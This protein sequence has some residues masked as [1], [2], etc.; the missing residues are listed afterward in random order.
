M[1]LHPLDLDA[2]RQEFHSAKPFPHIV[3]DNFLE[4]GF[5]H[6]VIEGYPDFAAAWAKV[7]GSRDG[8]SKLNE[9]FKIQIS[10]DTKFAPPVKRL[11]DR[12]ASQEF[13]DD[14]VH[15]TGIKRLR[16]DPTLHGGGMHLTGPRGRLDV[17]VDFN[18]NPELELH[19]R[20][21]I[22][23]YLNQD[24]PKEWGGAVELWDPEVKHCEVSLAPI[25]NRCVIFETSDTSYHGV[26]PVTC[27]QDVARR[28]FAGYYYTQ[29]APE[30]WDGQQHS[31]R[32][33]PRPNEVIRDAVL[34]RLERVQQRVTRRVRQAKKLVSLLRG[35]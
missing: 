28:S 35:R 31:T 33:R 23:L 18:Y 4:E 17:H 16:S 5:L 24:W 22:L 30:G 3:I 1:V 26:E 9:K 15:I 19:R 11:S 7:E 21:N 12:L 20:L 25:A 13:L 14:L 32:F 8:F 29:E 34:G 2:L 27:P 6:E 10:D